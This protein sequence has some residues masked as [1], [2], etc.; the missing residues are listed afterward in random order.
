MIQPKNPNQGI[1]YI[2][3]MKFVFYI[4]LDLISMSTIDKS[5]VRGSVVT[6]ISIS[7]AISE[8]GNWV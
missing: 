7:V 2:T 3:S 5:M 4:I 6:T 8:Y 1:Q